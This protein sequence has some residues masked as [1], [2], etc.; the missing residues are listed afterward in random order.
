[1]KNANTKKKINNDNKK[2]NNREINFTSNPKKNNIKNKIQKE[3]N[4]QSENKFINKIKQFIKYNYKSVIIMLIF[5]FV[6]NIEFPYYIE[7]P[8]GTINLSKRIDNNYNKKHG[9]LNML[10][11]TQY[12]GNL[13]TLVLGQIFPT[14]DIYEISNQQISNE[15]SHEIYLRNKVMLDNSIQNATFVAYQEAGKEITIK[16]TKNIVIATT[17]ENGIQIGDNIISVDNHKIS[18]INELK[19][20]LN[21]KNTGDEVK[22]LLERDNKEKTIN[23]TLDKDK[24]LGVAMITNYEYELPE[25]LNINFRNGEGG[26]SGGL[27]L[28]LGIYSEITG[29]DILKGRNIAGTGTIDIEGN[30]GEIDGVKYKIAGAVKDK[31]DVVLVSP[32]NYEE[33]KKVVKENNYNIELV[34]VSTFKEAIEYLTK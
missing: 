18:N 24:I 30:I 12:R 28:T 33:A 2:I 14:W 26:S 17:K 16:D 3:E 23:I 11:V 10:Y 6:V 8:G 5:I 21:S 4:E 9:S 15:T 22:V 25:E 1:M 13:V 32:Y 34:E 20:Y 29:I 31:M 27:I 7:A 19:S